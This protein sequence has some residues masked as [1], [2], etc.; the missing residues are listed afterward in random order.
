MTDFPLYKEELRQFVRMTLDEDIG[1]GDLTT[2]ATIPPHETL[3][4]VMQTRE[5]MVLGGIPLALEIIHTVDSAIRTDVHVQDG[6]E[7]MAGSVILT[8]E[9][10]ARSILTAERSALNILQHLSGIATLTR[11]YVREIEHTGC[12]LLD[13]RKTIPGYRKLAKYATRLGGA[14]NHRMRLD[15]G[16][17]IKDNHIAIAGG[18]EAAVEAARNF[19]SRA[20][21]IGITVE[22]D[23]LDQAHKAVEAGADRLL[24]DNMALD[25]LEEAVSAFKGKVK[26]EASGG[27][28]LETIKAIAE[29]GVDYI[30]V[31]RITQSAPAVD[32]GLDHLSS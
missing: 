31:G 5:N 14:Q 21:N 2:Q 1:R 26:L 7:V 27:V 13:T 30:S 16:M 24:L 19:D 18:V 29:T 32:I 20:S 12:I 28:T 6:V 22:C 11:T 15:D 10:N 23:T 4:A 8:L 9:G 17:L 3:K 25:M